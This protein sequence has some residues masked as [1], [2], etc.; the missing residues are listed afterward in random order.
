V[1]G[2]PAHLV[3]HPPWRQKARRRHG[4]HLAVDLQQPERARLVTGEAVEDV[5][6]LLVA[7][8]PTVLQR[9]VGVEQA[10][11]D[12]ADVGFGREADHPRQPV[13]LLDEHVVVEQHE[14]LARGVRC[15]EVDPP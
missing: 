11:A 5:Q 14:E 2:E 3:E 7:Q 9:A 4:R 6:R 10:A 8:D 12:D 15:A 1:L 13:A